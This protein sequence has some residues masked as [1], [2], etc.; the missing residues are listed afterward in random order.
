MGWQRLESIFIAP[1]TDRSVTKALLFCWGPVECFGGQLIPVPWSDQRAEWS[2]LSPLFHSSEWTPLI[3]DLMEP[4]LTVSAGRSITHTVKGLATFLKL[5]YLSCPSPSHSHSH[6]PCPSDHLLWKSAQT[7]SHNTSV[8]GARWPCLFLIYLP[9]SHL[10]RRELLLCYSITPLKIWLAGVQWT[11]K[12]RTI[13]SSWF[14]QS[15]ILHFKARRARR[16]KILYQTIIFTSH[17]MTP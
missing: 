13:S 7:Q 9:N 6:S 16:C 8:I 3:C 2:L 15:K 14:C 10:G 5:H 4:R 1:S 11:T 17:R 12:N